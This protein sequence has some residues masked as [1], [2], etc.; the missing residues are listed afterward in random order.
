ML[1]A[2]VLICNHDNTATA[3]FSV[4]LHSLVY[5]AITSAKLF[6]MKM[7]FRVNVGGTLGI[8]N[9]ALGLC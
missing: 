6:Q 1:E 4:H 9:W 7:V 2:V 5:F 3:S 8:K